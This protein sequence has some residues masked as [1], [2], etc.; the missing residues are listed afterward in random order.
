VVRQAKALGYTEPD[1]RDDLRGM[2]VARKLLI[3]VRETRQSL[4]LKDIQVH[5][6]VPTIC[7]K[8]K[9]VDEFMTLL[10]RADN[11]FAELQQ[12]ATSAGKVLR[13]IARFENRKATIALQAVGPEHPFYRLSG[14]DNIVAFTT[15][16]YHQRP[17]V[18]QGP[19]AGAQVTAA[20]VFANIIRI[21]NK[22]SL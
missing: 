9:S 3:L 15:K 2:D 13:Y 14:S 7:A 11:H 16:R 12:Q 21:A 22:V 8:A 1:P 10:S 19:G 4:E 6:L 18:I 5:S 20:G 17:L